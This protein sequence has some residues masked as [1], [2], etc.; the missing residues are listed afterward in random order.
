MN[1]DIIKHNLDVFLILESYQ[2][3]IID[4]ENKVSI[5]VRYWQ[6]LRRSTD[7]LT[8]GGSS[9]IATYDAIKLTYESIRLNQE[10][11]Q[12]NRDI[13][14]KSLDNLLKS[15]SLTYPDYEDLTKLIQKEIDYAHST[16]ITIS[17]NQI[18]SNN[19]IVSNDKEYEDDK[20]IENI[21]E[22][23]KNS[24]DS[25]CVD[26]DSRVE[27][28][29]VPSTAI[30]TVTTVTS[31]HVEIEK[32][33]NDHIKIAVEDKPNLKAVSDMPNKSDI[34]V[35]NN[36][37]NNCFQEECAKMLDQIK[38]LIEY[39]TLKCGGCQCF[40]CLKQCHCFDCFKQN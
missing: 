21:N 36:T 23:L 26:D 9:K 1:L 19:Q 11:Y 13:I 10:Y 30:T 15:L 32:N 27:I 18:E 14:K 39:L 29:I 16:I 38:A 28:V 20:P 2:K 24:K 3:L 25:E 7:N 33:N 22:S 12:L 4:A 31:L 5:D 6:F 8:C 17:D 37:K 35:I 40:N 34:T